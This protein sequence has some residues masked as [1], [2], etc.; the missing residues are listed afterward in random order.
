MIDDT[1]KR[2]F[3]LLALPHLDAAYNL[4]R[5]LTRNND[6][7]Q[8]VV[9][10]AIL[11]AMRYFG[12]FRGDNARPWLLQIVRHTSYTWMKRNRPAEMSSLD[13]DD[14]AFHEIAA[15]AADEPSALAQRGDE[16]AQLNRALAA[17]PIAFREVLVLRELEDL[18]Y[19]EIARIADIP[20]GTVMSRLARA[21]GLMRQ[22][23]APEARPQLRAV[24]RTAPGGAK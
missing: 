22:A 13:E 2:R 5:W 16:R 4:A 20:V 18:S 3:E 10:E 7:A 11:R 14:D 15:P 19:Q 1:G 9:Q 23:L 12:A 6:D 17:L 24:A 8:D 21:R